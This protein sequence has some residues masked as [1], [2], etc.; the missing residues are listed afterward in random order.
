MHTSVRANVTHNPSDALMKGANEGVGVSMTTL[1]ELTES[2]TWP[3]L[4]VP[5]GGCGVADADEQAAVDMVEGYQLEES[6]WDATVL[7]G[8]ATAGKSDRPAAGFS[9]MLVL[10]NILI[11]SGLGVV[12][13]MQFSVQTYGEDTVASLRSWRRNI[14]HSIKYLDPITQNSLAEQVCI[15]NAG[16]SF[17][18]SQATEYSNVTSYLDGNAGNFQV[19]LSLMQTTVS[20]ILQ[21]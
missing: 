4:Q 16:L 14:A 1:P 6:I 21:P 17:G 9:I 3:S 12:V 8:A 2:D 15:G 5:E 18:N 20:H 11:Q 10:V 19:T 7:I 13:V